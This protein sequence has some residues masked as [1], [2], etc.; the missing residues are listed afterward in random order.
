MQ[1]FNRTESRYC[2]YT[3]IRKHYIPYFRTGDAI[4]CVICLVID[5][6]FFQFPFLICQIVQSKREKWSWKVAIETGRK[7]KKEMRCEGI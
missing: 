3:I 5:E 4:G 1:T 2:R 6:K 7:S